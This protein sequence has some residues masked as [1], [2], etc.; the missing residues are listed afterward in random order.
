MPP[1]L[2]FISRFERTDSR[3]LANIINK[4]CFLTIDK[5]LLDNLVARV[6][7]LAS[8]L[9]GFWGILSNTNLIASLSKLPELT[10]ISQ[11]LGSLV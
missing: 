6:I 10:F 7:M 3:F 9:M 4:L 1:L 8:R 2:L 11:D 5:T